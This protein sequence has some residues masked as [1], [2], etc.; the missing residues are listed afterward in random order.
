MFLTQ[1][2]KKKTWHLNHDMYY[3]CVL[4]IV[5][6]SG[7]VFDKHK[8]L[9]YTFVRYFLLHDTVMYTNSTTYLKITF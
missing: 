1:D 9:P 7:I 8:L 5:A 4:D 3:L 6:A 2:K